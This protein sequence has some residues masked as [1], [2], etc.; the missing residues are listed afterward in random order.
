ML[1][2]LP[3][4]DGPWQSVS[5]DLV[6]DL[7]VCCGF[8]SIMVFVDRFSRLCVLAAC[9][10]TI[11][12]PQLAQLFIDKVFVRF[13]MPTSIV[14]DRDPRFTSHFWRAFVKLLGTD[15]AMS[16]AYHPQTD[17]QTERMNRTMEDMLRGFVGPRQDDWCK[18]L[19]MVEFAYNN[20]VQASTLHTPYFLNHG[21]HPLTPLSSAVPSRSA[22]PAVS[23][24][25]EGLQSALKSAKSN[26][27]S[28]QQ[29][30]KSH[31]DR[32][33]RDHPFKVGDQVLLAA[34]KNQLPPGLSSKLSAK[35]FGPF[36]IAAAVGT[37][38]FRLVLPETVNIH[39]VFHVSQ[40]KPYV[41]SSSPVTVTSPPP[42]YADKRGGVY[43]VEAI[44]AKKRVGK[45]WQ[46]LVKWKGYDETENTWEPLAHV[47]HLADDVA[48]APV[49]S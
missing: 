37:R 12:A 6:T 30:Q 25:V 45:S 47:R 22:N 36:L 31:A 34:R 18:Y 5:L 10:K 9:T 35:Y 44:I 43:E 11:T 42:L 19:S 33:R 46:Y 28:A 16:T 23:E 2:P 27:A 29:R 7:L 49:L 21:R 14:S 41:S 1:Q 4:P 32:R 15:L 17:G 8:D 39:P 20:S 48:A 3:I 40:L 13:G 24:W 26:L 38:A